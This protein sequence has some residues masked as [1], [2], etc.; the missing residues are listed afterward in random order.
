MLDDDHDGDDDNVEPRQPGLEGA[1]TNRPPDDGS[2]GSDF[3]LFG[4]REFRL[5]FGA[6]RK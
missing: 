5:R 2:D 6:R 4:R 3:R 1:A